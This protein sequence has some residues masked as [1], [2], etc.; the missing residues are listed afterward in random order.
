[1]KTLHYIF[2]NLKVT[3]RK[4]SGIFGLYILCNFVAV[5]VILFSHGVYQNYQVKTTREEKEVFQSNA[6]FTFGNVIEEDKYET[7]ITY[8]AD[9]TT[10]VGEFK[11]VIELLDT[12]TKKGF[13]GFSINY[14]IPPCPQYQ[15]IAY[16]PEKSEFARALFWGRIEYDE[17]TDKYGL[18]STL[19]ENIGMSSGRYISQQEEIMGA[20]VIVLP[21]YSYDGIDNASLVGEKIEF[22]GKEYEVIGVSNTGS[23]FHVP[24][25]SI[26]DDVE[27]I[28]ISFLSDKVI[29]TET[30]RKV[31]AAFRKVY[32]D[33]VKFPEMET[34]D[35]DNQTFYAS[36]IMMSVV[37]SALAGITLAILFRYIIYTRRKSLAVLRLNGCTRFKARIMYLTECLGISS[38]LYLLSAL[39]YNKFILPKLTRFFPSILEVYSRFTYLYIYL[40]FIGVL[41]VIINVMIS[42]QIDKQPVDMFKRR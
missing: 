15:T 30:F 10:T 29:T 26:P 36:I 18:Y 38:I 11:K 34:I 22:L 7:S 27:I 9:G 40:V 13:T 42:F 3:I 2:K 23:E 28:D 6:A 17:K 32:G 19:L 39:C 5:L 37:L 21:D 31:K 24:F 20:D 16:Q 41:F 33:Y 25:L 14:K 12:D 1:M 35:E 8:I 4:S